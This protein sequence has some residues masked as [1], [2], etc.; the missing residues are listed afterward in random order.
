MADEKK[1]VDPS[2]SGIYEAMGRTNVENI[3]HETLAGISE[4]SSDSESFDA[5]SGNEHAEDRPWR[6]SHVVLGKSTIKQG[7]LMQ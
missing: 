3:A 4:G 5:E 6:P 2:L 1:V 7:K